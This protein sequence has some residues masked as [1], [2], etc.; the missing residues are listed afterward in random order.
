MNNSQDDEAELG[1]RIMAATEPH[2]PEAMAAND[3]V[4]RS[5]RAYQMGHILGRAL[6]A[7]ADQAIQRSR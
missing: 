4:H 1:R 2:A 6:L 5:S 7:A 3:D